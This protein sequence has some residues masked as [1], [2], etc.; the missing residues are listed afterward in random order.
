MQRVGWIVRVNQ[1]LSK[2]QHNAE[3]VPPQLCMGS[4][5]KRVL[6][7]PQSACLLLLTTELGV[8]LQA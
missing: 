1:E 4:V 7:Y 3:V 6:P 5:F 2:S 8:E